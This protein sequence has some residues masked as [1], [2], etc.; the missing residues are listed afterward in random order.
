MTRLNTAKETCRL[1]DELWNQFIPKYKIRLDDN[2]NWAYYRRYDQ[3]IA[4]TT[5]ETSENTTSE[6]EAENTA[7]EFD[8]IERDTDIEITEESSNVASAQRLVKINQIV[9]NFETKYKD[10]SFGIGEDGNLYVQIGAV[11]IIYLL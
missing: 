2:G 9:E 4:I 8:E 3:N 11:N 1:Y 10:S 5:T 6:H 7:H